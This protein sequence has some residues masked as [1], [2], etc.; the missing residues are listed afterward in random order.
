[1]CLFTGDVAEA[2]LLADQ[3]QVVTDASDNKRF[4]DPALA[5]ASFRG[6]IAAPDNSLKR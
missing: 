4:P 3:V 5:V 6:T 2:A 1:M